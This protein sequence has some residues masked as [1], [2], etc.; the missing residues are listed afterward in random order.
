[1]V[2]VKVNLKKQVVFCYVLK[3][4]LQCKDVVFKWYDNYI[5]QDNSVLSYEVEWNVN[6]FFQ[7]IN[8]L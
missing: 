8:N 1:M 3:I 5:F 2:F 6:N 4:V 7:G